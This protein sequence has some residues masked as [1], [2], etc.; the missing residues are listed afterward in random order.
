MEHGGFDREH[1]GE[2]DRN[3]KQPRQPGENGELN[4]N[5]SDTHEVEDDPATQSSMCHMYLTREGAESGF[6]GSR[7]RRTGDARHTGGLTSYLFCRTLPA[8]VDA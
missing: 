1:G 3:V 7:S 5:T 6:P 8:W 4:R 2:E